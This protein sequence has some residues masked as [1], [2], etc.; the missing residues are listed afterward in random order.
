[1]NKVGLDR[2]DRE[3]LSLG[4]GHLAVGPPREYW[5]NFEKSLRLIYREGRSENLI[6]QIKDPR[7]EIFS[8][9]PIGRPKYG[10]SISGI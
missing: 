4:E 7:N 10:E 6:V 3:I 5:Q 9:L 8:N 2:I 1:M